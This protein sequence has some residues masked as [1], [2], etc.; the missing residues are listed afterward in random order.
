MN[1]NHAFFR[2]VQTKMILEVG[3]STKIL[4]SGHKLNDSSN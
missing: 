2:E 4:R 3:I 1:E